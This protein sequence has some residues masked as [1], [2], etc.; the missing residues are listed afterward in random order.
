LVTGASARQ[1]AEHLAQVE[2]ETIGFQDTNPK[3]LI[4]LAKKL[5]KLNARLD[6]REPAA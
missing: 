4:P 1:I 3:M 2:A 5:L 6:P